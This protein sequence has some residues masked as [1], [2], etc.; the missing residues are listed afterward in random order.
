MFAA[1]QVEAGHAIEVA[2]T[3]AVAHMFAAAHTVDVAAAVAWRVDKI[4]VEPEHAHRVEHFRA[5]ESM[6]FACR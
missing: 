6:G 1:G 3:V 5:V 2:D 4:A